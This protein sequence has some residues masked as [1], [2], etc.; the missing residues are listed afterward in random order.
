MRRSRSPTRASGFLSTPSARRATAQ[1]RQLQCSIFISIH[2][3]REEG[4]KPPHTTL[5][6]AGHF[7]P[8][9]PRGG[10][11]GGAVCLDKTAFISIHALREEGDFGCKALL[12][13]ARRF[14]STPSARRATQTVSIVR[15]ANKNFY[16]RPPRGGRPTQIAAV[17]EAYPISIH[18]LREEGDDKNILI[19]R[20][21]SNFYP[22]PPRGGRRHR[23]VRYFGA[24]QISIHALR[25]EGDDIS[26]DCLTQN[27]VFL[28]TPSA[29]R[30]TRPTTRSARTKRISIHA[31]REEGD[32]TGR[33]ISPRTSDFYPRP[34]RGGRPYR[35]SFRR[36]F[37]R[38][39]YPR[40]PR[41]GRQLF[42]G[43]VRLMS[44][45]SIHALREEGDAPSVGNLFGD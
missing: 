33:F 37:L 45:I 16:P 14:L 15:H 43:A 28:S 21:K 42:H 5:P 22:R 24:G 35:M 19:V 27:I 31:L 9:P 20:T 38:Y 1:Y 12:E 32:H 4:D 8:R 11:P 36:S 40:P 17:A 34:P 7:Y 29:R 13:C 2:A 6:S 26:S 30:A 3:L 39:F 23:H 10:R 44:E 41:G 18:A 25:E